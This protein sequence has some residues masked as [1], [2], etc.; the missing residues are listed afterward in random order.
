LKQKS[1]TIGIAPSTMTVFR[2]PFL[3]FVLL[4]GFFTTFVVWRLSNRDISE[5][6]QERFDSRAAQIVTAVEQR[7]H[8]YEQVLR[9]GVGL[10]STGP[11]IT[12]DQWHEYVENVNLTKNYPGIQNFAVDFPIP[13]A[14]KN[15]H[16]AQVRAEGHPEYSISPEQPE[17]PVYH[18][19]VYVEPFGGRNLRAFGFD[20]YTNPVRRE[21][22]NR[23]IDLGLPSVS[24][25][26]KLAQETNVDVQH[27]FIYCL[28]VYHTGRLA[29][30]P[31]QRRAALRALICGGFRANDLMRGIFGAS[32]SDLELEVFDGA[33]T[34]ESRM[35]NSSG[36]GEK[37]AVS[38]L[39]H[40]RPVEIG[41]RTWNLRVSANQ[42]FI[43]SIS[44]TQSQLVVMAGTLL[45]F[46]LFLGIGLWFD[47]E[48]RTQERVRRNSQIFNAVQDSVKESLLVINKSGIVISSNP[49][50]AQRLA[51]SPDQLIGRSIFEVM[52]P[53]IAA[54]WRALGE[55]VMRSGQS[56]TFEDALK[57]RDYFNYLY[58]VLD[59]RNQCEA[60]VIVE[61][62]ITLQKE[63]EKRILRLNRVYA[64]LSG[65]NTLIVR[66]R[67]RD[68]LFREACRIAVEDG[69]F[70]MAWIGVVDR[71]AMKIVP[72]AS[73]GADA[74]YA[75]FLEQVRERL[76]LLDGAPAGYGPPAMAVREKQEVVVNDV[77]ADP[78]I[79][80]KNEHAGR[81]IRS[82]VS[83][84]LLI[85][86]EPV[87]VFTLHAAEAGYF[88]EAEM[89]LLRQLAGDI[90]FAIDHL[91]KQERLNYLAYYDA[92]TGLANRSL[93]LERVAQYMRSAASGGH[94]LAVALIDLERFK[95]I[96]D[97]LG[98]PAGDALLKQVAEWLTGV[99]GDASLL[100]RVGADHFAGVLPQIK[101]GGDVARL[102]EKTMEAF[103]E[104]PFRLNDA[105][106]RIAAKVG[107]AVFPDDGADAETL[108]RN[109]EAALK[110][111]KA[112]GDRY[113]FHT[114]TMTATVAGK[115]TLE[116]QLR[117]ALDN[118]EFVLHYQPKVNL[119]SGKMT[120]AEALIRWNDPR[121]GLVP[122]GRFIPILEETGLIYDVGRWALRQA[123]KDYLR[124]RSAG[125]AAVRIA[126]NVSPLQLRHRGFIAEIEQAIGIDAHAAD[127]LELELTESLIMA[128]VKHNIASLQAIRALDV[129]IAID[130]FGTG[131]SSLSYLAKLPVDTL[132]ID[133]SFVIDMTAA[134][135]GL[136][137][138]STIINLAHS[139]KLNVVAEGVETEEQSRLLR[140]L[141]CDE[142]QGFLFS[143]PVPG[144]IFETRFLAP[145]R[146]G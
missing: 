79:R 23:A 103:V 71:S 93:F 36:H 131:F 73:A 18:S 95:N 8:S 59:P 99:T 143:K 90:A 74:G 109:A 47:I 57:G 122:P 11:T 40:T 49:T 117:Q 22:M 10:F 121:T 41:G 63:H 48:R 9:G 139:L 19:L 102:L 145:P 38:T 31:D 105:V 17:R 127:G 134:P 54:K 111:A 86:D 20:M 52:P 39:S 24:G 98:R 67:D 78:R 53:D 125:L 43:N 113:L 35:Y 27:G 126:V 85:A 100:A 110:K 129:S 29:F 83:L 70:Q 64:V 46:A 89:K 5:Q 132:K 119:A 91:D 62:D 25:M 7:M 101:Q 1:V 42:A 116:N 13:A 128:D 123:I 58:P 87:A 28:P 107:V 37:I 135:E 65:I 33:I 88:D 21:A 120:S 16:I 92:L 82:L 96:N 114:R 2:S 56:I 77:E 108:F 138:V 69:Q 32:T 60:I 140:L 34:P 66:V 130:D 94:K 106:F 104:H 136:A 124:W 51:L 55:E 133:R 72:V 81:G 50:A 30:T 142:M 146:A 14:E 44:W 84:P 76:S 61:T 137:L 3:W 15:A 4:I 112:G 144:A 6:T 75:S 26:V 118:E 80:H 12:R 141:A 45:S 68:E 97:S 115:L